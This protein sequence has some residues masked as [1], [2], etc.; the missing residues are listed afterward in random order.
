MSGSNG[1]AEPRILQNLPSG[2]VFSFFLVVVCISALL[3]VHSGL[4]ESISKIHGAYQRFT[5]KQR[6]KQHLTFLQ[7]QREKE[8]WKREH[9]Y[10]AVV[11]LPSRASTSLMS[12]QEYERLLQSKDII[13]ANGA[14]YIIELINSSRH[15]G[16]SFSIVSTPM[17]PFDYYMENNE[18]CVSF[19]IKVAMMDR[20]VTATEVPFA[21]MPEGTLSVIVKRTAKGKQLKEKEFH[22]GERTFLHLT[23]SYVLDP[24]LFNFPKFNPQEK[25]NRCI[26]T[27]QTNILEG[28]LKKYGRFEMA[29]LEIEPV[30][31]MHYQTSNKVR[32][33]LTW[34]AK[35]VKLVVPCS[36]LEKLALKNSR[37][38]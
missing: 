23:Y 11:D 14:Q 1:S 38:L 7:E 17:S 36:A 18:G 29:L 3:S 31:Y 24:A 19:R 10:E 26:W 5:N 12:Q 21:I 2:V 25:N 37:P 22:Q 27:G 16:S 15:S 4:R 8:R 34:I 32:R 35:E 30:V 20:P 13:E 9:Q 6:C 33:S 28:K